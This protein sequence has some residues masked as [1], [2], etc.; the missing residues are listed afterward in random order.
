MTGH[1]GEGK[2]HDKRLC[3]HIHH[4]IG[5]LCVFTA[6]LSGGQKNKLIRTFMLVL[7]CMIL[8]TGGSFCMRSTLWPGISFWYHMSILGLRVF[9]FQPGV[10]GH[11]RTVLE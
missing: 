6:D 2:Q 3:I 7:I 9:S 10:C 1:T 11:L 4:R 8:W 5:L